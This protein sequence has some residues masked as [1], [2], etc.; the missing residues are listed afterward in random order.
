[1]SPRP[2]YALRPTWGSSCAQKGS[3]R[4]TSSTGAVAAA[5][6]SARSGTRTRSVSSLVVG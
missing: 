1:M 2:R 5:V 6:S 3:F 4:T